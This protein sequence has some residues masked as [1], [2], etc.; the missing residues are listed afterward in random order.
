MD[1]VHP[2]DVG[3]IDG[4]I[5]YLTL[6]PEEAVLFDGLCFGDAAARL[7]RTRQPAVA[8]GRLVRYPW[9]LVDQNPEQLVADFRLRGESRTAG[10]DRSRWSQVAILGAPDDV[11]IDPTAQIDPFVV[12]DARRGPISIDAGVIVQPFTRIEGPCYIGCGSRLFRANVREGTTIGPNC[13]VGGEIEA[14]ILH[15]YV[16]KYHD[17]FLGH[18]YVCPWVNLGALTTNSDLKNDYS[19][20]SVP[21]DGENVDTGT[22]KV[23]C[24]I[25]DHTKTALGSLFN[26]GS[27]VGVMCMVLPAGELLP[28]SVPSFTR[29]WHGIPDDGLDLEAALETARTAMGRRNMRLT[30]AQEELLRYVHEQTQPDREEAILRFREKLAVRD[31][32]PTV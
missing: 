30:D 29:I 3:L 17:G 12:L 1:A 23:G 27:T 21:I 22:T 24:F 10:E 25:G 5:A 16:N 6:D 32:A 28:K 31:G 11:F 4:E 7:A 14:S 9:D 20:V 18:A 19:H 15:G 8:D 26:T 2:D 13:R